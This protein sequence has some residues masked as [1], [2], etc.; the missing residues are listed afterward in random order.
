MGAA[1]LILLRL[2]FWGFFLWVLLL[3][4]RSNNKSWAALQNYRYAHRGLHSKPQIPENSLPAFR[5]AIENGYGAE[6]D[7]HLLKDGTRAGIHDAEME[8]VTGKKA[9]IEELTLPELEHFRL[10]GT[11]ERIPLFDEVLALF[12]Q[13]APLIIELKVHHNNYKELARAVCRRLD[14]YQ[15]DFCLESFDFRAVN[16]VRKLRPSWCR[17]Q[18]AYNSLIDPDA[19][20]YSRLLRFVTMNLLTD[21]LTRPDF[22]AYNYPDRKNWSNQLATRIWHSRRDSWTIRSMEEL[23]TAEKE[24]CIPIF[25]KFDPHTGNPV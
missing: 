24:G 7:V 22:I 4:G 15:G 1:V 2:L 10:E 17:G 13:Q 3:M 25:E 9:I 21:I 12:E 14:S 5:R 19:A 23:Q 11:D 18:L 16:Q 8:R 6:L 20:K